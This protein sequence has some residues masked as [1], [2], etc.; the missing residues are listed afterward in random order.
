MKPEFS[1]EYCIFFCLKIYFTFINSVDP[2]EMQLHAA[3]HLGLYYL[4]KCLFR[5]FENTMGLNR[6]F[7][8]L[9]TSLLPEST[10]LWR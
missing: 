8:N 3:L 9:K 1:K 6:Q 4:Q 2:D 5:D 10:S 7:L